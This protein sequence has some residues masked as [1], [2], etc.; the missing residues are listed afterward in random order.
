MALIVLIDKEESIYRASIKNGSINAIYWTVF[1]DDSINEMIKRPENCPFYRF[2]S[3]L[4]S[5]FDNY[6][7]LS[8]IDTKFDIKR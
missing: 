3:N 8:K 5:I 1:I 7:Y 6:R 4:A 2:I